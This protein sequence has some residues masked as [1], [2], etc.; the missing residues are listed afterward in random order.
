MPEINFIAVFV[1]A[2]I[3]SIMG[4]IYYGPLFE[5]QWLSSLGKTKE[6]MV[7]SNMAITYGLAILMAILVSMSLKMTI[8]LVHRDVNSAGEMYFSSFHTFRHGALHGAMLCISFVVPIIVSLSLFQ[9]V[10]GK[11]IILN[12]IFWTVCLAIMGGILDVWN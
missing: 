11:N 4:A 2:L 1:A 9:K 12:I 10:S 6:E 7:P 8:E 5:K 3:P